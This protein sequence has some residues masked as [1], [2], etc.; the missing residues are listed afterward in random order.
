MP[1]GGQA[2]M[3]NIPTDLTVFSVAGLTDMQRVAVEEL[4]NL[5]ASI[6]EDLTQATDEQAERAQALKQF[7]LDA[8]AEVA[9]RQ[10]NASAFTID[11]TEFS[12]PVIEAAPIAPEAVVASTVPVVIDEPEVIVAASGIGSQVAQALAISPLDEVKVHTGEVVGW[13]G[14]QHTLVAANNI[15]GVIEGRR[16]ESWAEFSKAFSA[17]TRSYP[18]GGAAP[19]VLPH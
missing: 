13:L 6:G 11:E 9:K 1:T 8:K 18:A 3:F 5:R 15:P 2:A 4:K 10:S 14:E 17:R 19:Q 7:A 16:L 12:I